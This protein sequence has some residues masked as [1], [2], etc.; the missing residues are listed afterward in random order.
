MASAER[1]PRAQL[2][3]EREIRAVLAEMDRTVTVVIV[4]GKRDR[5]ALERLGVETPILTCAQSAGLL[6]FAQSIDGGP[7][8]ILT[9]FD[10]H[11]RRLNGQLRE[12]LPDAH[13]EVRWRRTLG[14]LLTQRGHYDIEALN[15]IGNG[16]V[17]ESTPWT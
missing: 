7:V 12:Y 9:D 3:W 16:P 8:A 2:A 17:W 15:G 11:G 6:A 13:V 14:L 4:E 10:D 1:N 5:C